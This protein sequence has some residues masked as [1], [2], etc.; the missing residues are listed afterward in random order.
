MNRRTE[1]LMDVGDACKT[2][3]A[4]KDKVDKLRGKVPENSA[5]LQLY[6]DEQ[7]KVYFYSFD[8]C[9]ILVN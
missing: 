1:A 4:R 6:V 8:L 3:K 9:R 7:Q 5:E 2:Y